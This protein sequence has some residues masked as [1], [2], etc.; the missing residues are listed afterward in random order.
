MTIR[1]SLRIVLVSE[2][3]DYTSDG[4]S[5]EVEHELT[6]LTSMSVTMYRLSRSL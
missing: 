5:L 6:A 2:F 3:D 1:S 4:A